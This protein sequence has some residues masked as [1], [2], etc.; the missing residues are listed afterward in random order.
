M[1]DH[2]T[3]FV[4]CKKNDQLDISNHYRIE[5]IEFELMK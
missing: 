4:Y 5:P 1:N 3:D 2:C